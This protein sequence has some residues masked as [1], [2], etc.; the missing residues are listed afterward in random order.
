M[1]LLR[2]IYR[3]FVLDERPSW[4]V[5]AVWFAVTPLYPLWVIMRSVTTAVRTLLGEATEVDREYAREVKEIEIIG[6]YP[7]FHLYNKK[8]KL[9]III[10]SYR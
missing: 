2:V 10:L 8:N 6:E 1:N 3:Y 5:W 7:H 4:R 9:L